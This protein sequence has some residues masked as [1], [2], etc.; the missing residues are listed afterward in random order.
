MCCAVRLFRATRVIELELWY[1]REYTRGDIYT[2]M[3]K[4]VLVHVCA[5]LPLFLNTSLLCDSTIQALNR[6]VHVML[7]KQTL[8]M[9]FHIYCT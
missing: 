9:L 5:S 6:G 4:A 3:Y 1:I 2:L 8:D 7:N